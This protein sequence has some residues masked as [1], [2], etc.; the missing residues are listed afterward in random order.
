MNFSYI[1]S[2]L[3]QFE[4]RDLI[5]LDAPILGNFSLSLTNIGLYLSI[6]AYLV[7]VIS[8]SSDNEGKIVPNNWSIAQESIYATVHGIVI[9]QIN[10]KEGQLYFPLMFVL[11]TFILVNNLIGM[12][13][14][15]LQLLAILVPHSF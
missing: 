13:P 7:F 2:P 4:I 1:I 11:F 15:S 8:I 6:A 3:D 12:I 14:Y 5:S 10:N 9:G